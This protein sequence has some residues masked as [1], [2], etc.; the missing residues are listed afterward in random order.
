[1]KIL[2]MRIRTRLLC[3]TPRGFLGS[4]ILLL[5]ATAGA[6]TDGQDWIEQDRLEAGEVLVSYGDD[7]RFRGLI[8]T[9]V[10]ID[11]PPEAIWEILTDCESAPEYVPHVLSCE[12]IETADQGRTQ[13]FLQE[14]KYAWFLPA[15]EHVF[16]LNYQPYT[17]M[18]V[19]RISGPLEHLDGV[20]RLLPAGDQSTLLLYDLELRVGLLMPH[21][22]VGAYLRRD[23]PVVLGGIRERAESAN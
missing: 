16:S 3:R 12:L 5:S 9:A 20:W 19:H 13:V 23:I 10:L 2:P 7:T 6:Q 22:A 8:K 4:W 1:M 14:I 18:D 15:F 21:F 17:R 11:A